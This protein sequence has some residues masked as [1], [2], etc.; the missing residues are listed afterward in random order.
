[1]GPNKFGSNNFAKKKVVSKNILGQTKFKFLVKKAVGQ[2][3][4]G[5]K[6]NMVQRQFGSNSLGPKKI[7]GSKIFG[8]EKVLAPKNKGPIKR[9]V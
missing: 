5:F 4:C 7:L 9:W 1:M 6:K 2:K 3:S 8:Q